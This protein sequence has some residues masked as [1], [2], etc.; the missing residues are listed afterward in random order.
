MISTDQLTYLTADND[1]QSQGKDDWEFDDILDYTAATILDIGVT[2][3]NSLSYVATF[4][5]SGTELDTGELLHLANEDAGRFYD[6][7]KDLVQLSS[8]IGGLFVPGYA[9]YRTLNAARSGRTWIGKWDQ[10]IVENESKALKAAEKLGKDSKEFL[11]ARS[12]MRKDTVKLGIAES[13]IYE[14]E[15]I[16]AMNKHGYLDNDYDMTDFAIGAGIGGLIIP[17]RLMQQSWKFR[18][19]HLGVES[20]TTGQ[21]VFT[22][23]VALAGEDAGQRLAVKGNQYANHQAEDIT[24]FSQ[25]RKVQHET[26]RQI[27]LNDMARDVRNMAQDAEL[28]ARIDTTVAK[29]GEKQQ[30]GYQFEADEALEVPIDDLIGKLNTGNTSLFPGVEKMRSLDSYKPMM[31]TME[32]YYLRLDNGTVEVASAQVARELFFAGAKAAKEYNPRAIPA[33][34]EIKLREIKLTAKLD[35]EAQGWLKSYLAGNL[36][37]TTFTGLTDQ[38]KLSKRA[39]AAQASLDETFAFGSKYKAFDQIQKELQGQVESSR[40]VLLDPRFAEAGM[41]SELQARASAGLSSVPDL[42]VDTRAVLAQP[43]NFK[44]YEQSTPKTDK[45]RLDAMIAVEREGGKKLITH[46]ADTL[47][48]LEAA[49]KKQGDWKE[50]ASKSKIWATRD[51]AIDWVWKEK[52]RLI[53]A[54]PEGSSSLQAAVVSGTPLQTVDMVKAARGAELPIDPDYGMFLYPKNLATHYAKQTP[55]QIEGKLSSAARNEEFTAAA[56]LDNSTLA[57]GHRQIVTAMVEASGIPELKGFL[58]DV[59]FSPMAKTLEAGLEKVLAATAPKWHTFTSRDHALRG[60]GVEGE[61]VTTLGKIF[62]DSVNSHFKVL[63]KRITFSLAAVRNDLESQAQFSLLRQALHATPIEEA[64]KLTYDPATRKILKSIDDEGNIAYL[65]FFGDERDIELTSQMGSWL[66]AWLPVQKEYLKM[67]NTIR[68]IAGIA[69]TPGAGIWMPYSELHK[70]HVAFVVAKRADDPLQ[71]RLITDSSAEGLQIQIIENRAKFAGSHDVVDKADSVA[72]NQYNRYSELEE[73]R[74]V[75]SS[76]KKL[77]IASGTVNPGQVDI[78][79]FINSIRNELYSKYR[80]IAQLGNS[81]LHNS[82]DFFAQREAAKA[83]QLKGSFK[84]RNISVPELVSATLLNKS[85]VQS[86]PILDNANNIT[87]AGIN[88]VLEKVGKAWEVIKGQSKGLE[89]DF[90]QLNKVMLE[91]N[92]PMPYK[93]VAAYERALKNAKVEDLALKRVQQ[94]QSV[95]VLLNLRLLEA[96]HASVTTISLPVIL[97]G[98]L[99]SRLGQGGLAPMKHMKDAGKFWAGDGVEVTKLKAIAEKHK[100][101]ES[102]VAETAAM[103]K[104]LTLGQPSI[105]TKHEKL[106]KLLVKPSNWAEGFV[107]EQAFANGYLLAKA[108][109]PKANMETLAASAYAF[110]SRTMG[111]YVPRQR[112]TL[113]QGTLGSMIGLY[114]TFM[115]TMG[116]NM[117]RYLEAGQAKAM[118]N[119]WAAQTS[120]F[121]FESLP[122]YQQFNQVLGARYSDEHEDFRTTLYQVFGEDTEQS[123]SAA[124]YLLYGAPSALFGNS[125]YTRATLNPRSPLAISPEAGL[126]LKPAIF[127]GIMQA[128]ALGVDLVNSITDPDV[129]K[130]MAQALAAQ[131]LW[132]P[133]ARNLEQPIFGMGESFDRLGRVIS[134]GEEVAAPSAVFARLFGT[135]PLKEMALRNLRFANTYYNQVDADRRGEYVK[136]LRRI[137]TSD[138]DDEA[139]VELYNGFMQNNGTARGWKQI[140]NDAYM[141]VERPY[142]ERLVAKMKKQPAI[143]D[144]VNGYAY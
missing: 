121:G 85:L 144:I 124:E 29:R 23:P 21:E 136:S 43:R 46:E 135:R 28:K 127:D 44:P 37:P 122:L 95:M 8:F 14:T 106:L 4:G 27:Q 35:D 120:M 40:A 86:A 131:S 126:T 140:S 22:T 20:A 128:G 11:A 105:Y 2:T 50:V 138:P 92:M 64:T 81:P 107:R 5:Q 78:D 111:N 9:A 42:A 51:E 143:Q 26:S 110:T 74:M 59:V 118:T 80:K 139:I 69:E 113:F 62:N 63:A 48:I 132:R 16:L 53:H 32:K 123:R 3:V 6:Q 83:G 97:Q 1:L 91:G 100:Y 76:M 66:E 41:I 71:V 99:T 57:D 90:N 75:D 108:L 117:Y 103:M 36:T 61:M 72:W 39:L 84:S 134:T 137:L 34:I 52:Q 55:V 15:F 125:L 73:Y 19:K 58:T 13:L 104:D 116:Q 7:N 88:I 25:D 70:E 87:T 114:Q 31:A 17:V 33:G 101:T 119:L 60:L 129:G 65:K 30:R 96:A 141:S 89:A 45:A 12:A 24:T 79:N 18:D 112:P 98:E 130:S 68:R 94:T 10:G 54:A 67:G 115:L 56:M 142:A 77:G 82:L 49:V 102:I 93:D 133:L 38:L 109:D 47:V